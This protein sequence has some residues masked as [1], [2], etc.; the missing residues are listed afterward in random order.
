MGVRSLERPMGCSGVAVLVDQGP[1]ALLIVNTSRDENLKIVGEGDQ[2]PIEHPV[3][4]TGERETVAH[5]IRPILL[6]RPDMR[7]IDFGAT[8]TVYQPEPGYRASLS[9]G[10]QD[11]SAED[12]VPYGAR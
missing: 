12:P 6:D 10:P 9:I 7:R 3:R 1:Y 4:R 2:S 11:R 8:A 5:D